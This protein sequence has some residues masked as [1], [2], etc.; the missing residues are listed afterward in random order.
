MRTAFPSTFAIASWLAATTAFGQPTALERT[1]LSRGLTLPPPSPALADEA[2]APL[3]NPAGLMQLRSSQLFYGHERSVA[4][5]DVIDGLYLSNT[6]F[7]LLAVGLSVEW[8]RNTSLPD[9][10][11]P[12]RRKTT[13][14]LA[15]GSPSFALGAGFSFFSSEENR[16][17]DRASGIDLGVLLRPSRAISVGATV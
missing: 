8:I 12:D 3:V 2:T 9:V 16:S 11:F 15:F 4:R 5:N 7:D 17:L 13:W 14:S 10:E 6:I 1:D